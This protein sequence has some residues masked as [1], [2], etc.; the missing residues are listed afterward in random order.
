MTNVCLYVILLKPKEIAGR[1]HGKEKQMNMTMIF[2]VLN[3][4]SIDRVQYVK[5]GLLWV[6]HLDKAKM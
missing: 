3:M 4:E 2:N 5:L 6:T 1:P